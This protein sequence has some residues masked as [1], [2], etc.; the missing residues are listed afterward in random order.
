MT[1]QTLMPKTTKYLYY[2][3]LT[4]YGL[5]FVAT[6]TGNSFFIDGFSVLCS[7]SIFLFLVSMINVLGG[8]KYTSVFMAIG[9]LLWVIG[10]VLYF[11]N[12]QILNTD[13]LTGIVDLIYD[14]P[15]YFFGAS[16]GAWL[17]ICLK[18]RRRDLS[19]FMANTFC[20]SIIAL[21]LANNFLMKLTSS[22]QPMSPAH[23]GAISYFYA[24][25]SILVMAGYLLYLIGF[26]NWLK[27]TVVTTY[28]I[29]GYICLDFG[30]MYYDVKGGD[31]ESDWVNFLYMTCMFMLVL[32]DY[33]QIKKQYVFPLRTHDWSRTSTA[34][35]FIVAIMLAI[36]D[37]LLM[38]AGWLN[39]VEVLF[40][41]VALAGY[42]IMSYMIGNDVLNESLIHQVEQQNE[43]LE[44]RIKVKTHDLV[45]ANK[46]LEKLSSTDLLT[47]L[48]NRRY[49]RTDLLDINEKAKITGA[50]YSLF[51]ID[52][53]HFKPVNDTYGHEMGDR[54]LEEFGKRM[55]ALPKEYSSYRMGGDE[56]LIVC[57]A[58]EPRE[59]IIS[60]A[61]SIK[62]LFNTPVLLDTYIFNLSA[63]IGISIFPNDGKEPEVLM[64]YADAAM[65]SVKT[66]TNKDDYRFYDGGLIQKVGRKQRIKDMLSK[67]DVYKDFTLFYQPQIDK[68]SGGLVGVE[69][70]PRM[71][72]KTG[73]FSPA[74]LI[75]VAEEMGVMHTLGMF[76]AE[77]SVETVIGWK[78]L[79]EDGISLTINLSPLQLIDAEFIESL[80][81]VVKS[82][83]LEPANINLDV[84]NEVVMGASDAA[85]ETLRVL[86]EFGFNLSLND[87][88]GGDINLAYVMD[89]GFNHIKLSRTLIGD[90]ETNERDYILIK[91][92][93]AMAE[94]TGIEVVAVGVETMGQAKLL[95]DMGI[96]R[97]QG[98]LFGKP[99]DAMTFYEQY[100]ARGNEQ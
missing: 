37:V 16:L 2:V 88:G 90:M 100:S 54:V 61:E 69:V 3:T 76:I 57:D 86:G 87:F 94:T 71:L 70:F 63:S 23:L 33:F 15:N 42:I 22:K 81:D 18:D 10:D 46:E 41:I 59:R 8:F 44:E 29:I 83:G 65:Y 35:R 85:K 79:F 48:Y 39:L 4:L 68:A 47:G 9:I 14:A 72:E 96:R 31:A 27:G 99:V 43:I 52:L 28:G 11:I 40:I 89:C 80:G 77:K 45:V 24:N 62:E 26:K 20:F 91:S 51:V 50:S 82:C 66:S 36:D 92:I 6:I 78:D 55:R 21:V 75:P 97:M 1:E 73:D 95:C 5:Y 38:M 60:R 93:V 12:N 34:V 32:G 67:L 25:F 49:A 56:F 17:I 58:S 30:Y 74:E 19:F 98:F 53:N 7:F 13:P 64:S 84:A